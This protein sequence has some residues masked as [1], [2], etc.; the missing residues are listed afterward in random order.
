MTDA[1]DELANI[2]RKLVN[3][4][5]GRGLGLCELDRPNLTEQGL[6]E[7]LRDSQKLP[8]TRRGIKYAVLRREILPTRIGNGNY[9]SMR[10]G[11][12]W[13]RSRKAK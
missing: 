8:V 10:D 12:D 4:T 1:A 11:L 5:C 7:Y 3:E 2:V 6:F 13:I 9:F